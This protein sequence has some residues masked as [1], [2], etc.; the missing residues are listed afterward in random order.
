M[1]EYYSNK[2]AALRNKAAI[3]GHHNL[4]QHEAARLEAM[5]DRDREKENCENKPRILKPSARTRPNQP[6]HES[7]TGAG[8]AGGVGESISYDR[9]RTKA[10]VLRKLNSDLAR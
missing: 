6:P 7:I 9:T 2:E 3:H 10:S 8:G 1:R 4:A 5:L